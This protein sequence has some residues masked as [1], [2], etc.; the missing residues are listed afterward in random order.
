[1][2]GLENADGLITPS[3]CTHVFCEIKTFPARLSSRKPRYNECDEF[4][5]LD[6]IVEVL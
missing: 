3:L 2:V 6:N 5:L 4:S 1:M